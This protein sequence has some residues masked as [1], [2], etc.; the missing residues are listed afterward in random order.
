MENGDLI[1]KYKEE[2]D[3]D[4]ELDKKIENLLKT[5][6][7]KWTGSGFSVLDDIRDIY[8]NVLFRAKYLETFV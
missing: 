3:I 6:G 7:Y 8:F 2:Q 5:F 1:V 4:N